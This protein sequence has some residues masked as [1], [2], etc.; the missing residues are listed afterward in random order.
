MALGRFSSRT[1]R[2]PPV[3]DINITPLVDVMLVLVVIF[4][5]AAPLFTT[6]LPLQL[7]RADAP[8][9]TRG[10]RAVHLEMDGQGRLLVQGQP[11][12][13]ETL[14]ARLREQAMAQSTDVLQ[15][16]A[17]AAVAYGDLA[18]VMAAAQRAGLVRMA[19]VTERP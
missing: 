5:L 19:F 10:A 9:D 12:T 17:D 2:A 3:S 6:A 7:P 18:R 11:A 4:I 13:P 1:G 15:L 8:A 14:E 16:R